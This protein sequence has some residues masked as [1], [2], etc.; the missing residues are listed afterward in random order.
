VFLCPRA[1][2]FRLSLS[3]NYTLGV[4]NFDG[5]FGW[6]SYDT[7]NV[8]ALVTHYLATNNSTDEQWHAREALDRLF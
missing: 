8:G 1:L 5:H 7:D 4:E 3:P 2:L 6:P